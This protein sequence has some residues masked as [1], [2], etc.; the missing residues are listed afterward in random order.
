MASP[1]CIGGDFN[2]IIAP[3]EKRGGR[4]FAMTEGLELLSFMEVAEV[5]DAGFSGPSFTWS[6][7][8][9][10]WAT[11]WKR[12]DRVVMNEE[13]LGVA[14]NISVVHLASQDAEARLLRA[15]EV[16]ENDASEGAQMELQRAQG[17]LNRALA[18]EELYWHQ[19]ARV[20]WIRSGDRNSKYFH[21]VVKQRRVQ[22]ML[23]RIKKADE[24]W[25]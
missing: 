17:K 20:K 22:G 10:G 19:K 15:E 12:L 23:H 16:V 18:V 13:C 3:H 8:R 7:N 25:V 1:W 6:N 2:V 4:H 24:A 9:K 14:S 21:A 11:I 5:F